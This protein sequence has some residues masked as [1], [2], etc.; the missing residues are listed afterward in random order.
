MKLSKI[1]NFEIE[2]QE[3]EC[4]TL[5]EEMSA[6]AIAYSNLLDTV[7][8]CIFFTEHKERTRLIPKTT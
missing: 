3:T 2:A 7:L 4:S 1:R 5:R 6:L 8:A